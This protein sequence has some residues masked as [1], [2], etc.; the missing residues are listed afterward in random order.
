MVL[1]VIMPKQGMY[2]GDVTLIKW[3]VGDGVSISVG[4]VLFIMENEKVEIEI[5]AEDSGILVQNQADGFVGPVG[6]VIGYLVSTR[7]EYNQFHQDK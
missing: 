2:E 6:S 7:Q 3:L 4:D 1:E 5:E